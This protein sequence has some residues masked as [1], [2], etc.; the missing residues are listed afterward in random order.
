MP[1]IY[2]HTN[3]S[4]IY[5]HDNQTTGKKSA[6]EKYKITRC[7]YDIKNT[8]Q[9]HSSS[10]YKNKSGFYL[11][12]LNFLPLLDLSEIN[13]ASYIYCG[14]TH[15]LQ[16]NNISIV[17]DNTGNLLIIKGKSNNLIKGLYKKYT[18]GYHYQSASLT[19]DNDAV[20]FD[21]LYIN[22]HRMLIGKEKKTNKYYCINIDEISSPLDT[23]EQNITFRLNK[24]K[25]ILSDESL[26]LQKED[27]SELYFSYNQRN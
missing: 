19:N 7:I 16:K 17:L 23:P 22:R 9:K 11:K 24:Y 21:H 2:Y 12:K 20:K 26:T 1:K 25:K 10:T 13:V 8:A 6:T 14:L 4:S 5:L 3:N 15:V 18:S 27:M